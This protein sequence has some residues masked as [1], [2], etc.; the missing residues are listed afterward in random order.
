[1]A[2]AGVDKI[3]APWPKQAV[4]G[5]MAGAYVAL[6]ALFANLMEGGLYDAKLGWAEDSYHQAQFHALSNLVGGAVFPVG[7]IA[8]FLTGAN[9]YTG[10]CMYVVPALLNGST[11]RVRALGF[12][13]FSW[14]ANLAGAMFVVYFIAYQGEWTHSGG[15][16]DYVVHNAE[17]KCGLKWG[18]A[19]LRGVGANWLVCLAWWQGLSSTDTISKIAAVWLPVFT[20]TAIGFEHSIANMFYINIGLLEGAKPSVAQA[21]LHNLLPVTLGNFLGGGILLGL[22][23]WL[24]YDPHARGFMNMGTGATSTTESAH[25]AVALHHHPAAIHATPSDSRLTHG[26]PK[27][28]PT[29]GG[30]MGNL[31]APLRG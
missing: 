17:H 9:L 2:R 16:H 23:Q 1:M 7:L 14:I 11:S 21:L 8:I 20:F 28:T 18:V 22:A 3:L 19:L 25:S 27:W 26:G 5:F 30:G 12:L 13:G 10:N 15:V 6:G 4:Q 31:Q 24:T 29:I